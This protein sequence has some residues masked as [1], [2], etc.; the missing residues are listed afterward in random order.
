[1]RYPKHPP[2]GI[3]TLKWPVYLWFT[4]MTVI[5]TKMTAT[6]YHI[7]DKTAYFGWKPKE[8]FLLKSKLSFGLSKKRLIRP[9][10]ETNLS[11][12]TKEKCHFITTFYLVKSFYDFFTR[13]IVIYYFLSDLSSSSF[14]D[15]PVDFTA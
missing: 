5:F 11:F 7:F 12:V 2:P 14:Q 6:E 3:F 1:M 8:V 13:I 9:K 10:I 4:K 15:K